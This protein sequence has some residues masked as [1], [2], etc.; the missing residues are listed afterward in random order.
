LHGVRKYGYEGVIERLQNCKKKWNKKL[1]EFADKKTTHRKQMSTEGSK[2][3]YFQTIYSTEFEPI[4]INFMNF[5]N[6]S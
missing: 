6:S 2:S 3:T 1:E 4:L 5:K